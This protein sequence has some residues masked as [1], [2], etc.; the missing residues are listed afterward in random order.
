MPAVYSLVKVFRPLKTRFIVNPR[1]GRA[2]R[3]L[4]AVR[5]FA[6]MHLA[7]VV[8]TER[9]HHATELVKRAVDEG[10]QLI[11]CVGGDG[12]M[13][14]IA[15]A[16][17]A[18]GVTLGFVPS[19]SGDGLALS[20]GIPRSVPRALQILLTGQ[21]RLIDTAQVN[22]RPFFN[23]MGL[24]LEAEIAR[25]FATYSQRGILGYTRA[26]LQSFQ[27][28]PEES[29]TV[30]HD[31]GRASLKVCTLAVQNSEQLGNN[32]ISVPDARV[33]DGKLDLVATAPV[34]VVGALVLAGR[35]ISGTYGDASGV[36]WLRSA[37]YVI[38]RNAPGIIHVDGEPHEAGA[39]LEV[40]VR[41][42][43]LRVMAP[44]PDESEFLPIS[45]ASLAEA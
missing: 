31:R 7:E 37:R 36:T 8:L 23:A 22:D 6:G 32:F 25:R 12:T 21:P 9:A 20:L 44:I 45:P 38:E 26:A 42:H 39:R 30:H 28:R 13:N 33:E 34:G 24:G 18:T 43:S 35:M 29:I 27:S 3:Q 17:I 5:A 2:S 10:C 16:L 11:V 41:P 14:E 1:S 19:G 40:T 15:K 4:D